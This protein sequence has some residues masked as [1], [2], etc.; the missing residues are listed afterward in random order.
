MSDSEKRLAIGLGGACG[1]YFA[2]Y[3][4]WPALS[5]PIDQAQL[6]LTGAEAALQAEEEK[7]AIALAR[8]GDMRL[9]KDQSLSSNVSEA[10]LGYEQWLSDLAENVAKFRAPK[11]T[12]ETTSPSRDNSYVA[13]KIRVAGQGTLKQLREFL[14]RFHRA[15][16]LHQ[17]SSLTIEALDNSSNPLLDIV[18]MADA[19]SMRDAA[20]KGPTLFARSEVLSVD[21]DPDR[22]LT[23]ADGTA[24]WAVETPFEI[25]V[26]DQYLTVL[27]R[28]HQL[29]EIQ[30]TGS[31]AKAG[32]I[33]TLVE[34]ASESTEVTAADESA[35]SNQKSGSPEK[36][37]PAA[38][39]TTLARDWD[40]KSNT[41]SV[42][43]SG[44]F[45]RG[46]L[47]VRIGKSVVDVV[48]RREVWR[49]DDQRF[50]ADAG[51]VV[52][53]SPVHPK[54]KDATLADFDSLLDLNPFAK[55]RTLSPNFLLTG[56]RRLERGSSTVLTPIVQNLGPNAAAPTFEIVSELPAGMTF[57]D[58]RLNWTPPDDM[59]PGDWDIRIRAKSDALASPLE[60]TFKVSLT[61]TKKNDPPVLW[62]P[63]G[64]VV[65]VIGQ[66]LNF[67]VTATDNETA[68]EDLRF[69]AGANFP[70][71][72]LVNP[73]TG[74]VSWLPGDDV[75]PGTVEFP[76]NVT[77]NGD[78][79]QTSSQTIS[80]D[81]QEDRAIYTYLTASI[82]ADDRKQ[83]WLYDR[84]SNKRVIVQEGDAFQFAGFDALI[85]SIGRDFIL[86]Q[87]DRDTLRLDIG[88]S[89]RQAV[90]IATAPPPEPVTNE[91]ATGASATSTGEKPA[92]ATGSDAA[93]AAELDALLKGLDEAD[94]QPSTP[95]A[96]PPSENTKP[97]EQPATPGSP[98][99]TPAATDDIPSEPDG[100]EPASAKS[101]PP[102]DDE[103]LEG[104][105]KA[106]DDND[107]GKTAEP[108]EKPPVEE[109]SAAKPD[110]LSS[111]P[112]RPVPAQD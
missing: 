95:G 110:E 55:I 97:A 109:S 32:A 22:R 86:M 24:G 81:M 38:V 7:S 41:I 15:N 80:V 89:L 98:E 64:Q 91:G 11:V 53:A 33:V 31:E 20:V 42:A 4:I 35:G 58:G 27:E 18:V 34:T 16:V 29:W 78:P 59:E 87:Q 26:D 69:S 73:T 37:A 40:G 112:S 100:P 21:D 76:I 51:T 108:A 71:G 45:K 68:A 74:E 66:P 12:R 75:Q 17:I 84:S 90:V 2:F 103:D 67:V 49:I 44:G 106:L 101:T 93:T 63:E 105:L 48:A 94:R 60:D 25:R 13:I 79:Q 62:P 8:I 46:R 65:G 85:L 104:L 102:A 28:V 9:L 57:A 61:V 72:A 47:K 96:I 88:D 39:T 5:G 10:S 36:V 6:A 56:E 3:V 77:D 50:R 111:E 82:A 52:E 43:V 107:S 54:F 30:G 83:A 14:F 92:P 1:L 23:I 70:E 99:P 19:L